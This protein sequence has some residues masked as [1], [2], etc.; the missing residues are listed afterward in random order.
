VIACPSFASLSAE[1]VQAPLSGGVLYEKLGWYAVFVPCIVL[2]GLDLVGRLL[3]VERRKLVPLSAITGPDEETVEKT[4]QMSSAPLTPTNTN[5]C[6]TERTSPHAGE[7]NLQSPPRGEGPP[8]ELSPWS[9]F[10]ALLSSPRDVTALSLGC[11][12]GAA[13]GTLEPTC[14]DPERSNPLA[15][16]KLD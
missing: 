12:F 4:G 10:F 9:V 8:K 3:V 1:E 7:S 5:V 16:H 13:I 2:C 11:V 14:V 15:Y 6:K